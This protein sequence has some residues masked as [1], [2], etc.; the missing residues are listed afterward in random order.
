MRIDIGIIPRGL[1]KYSPN[2]KPIPRRHV[3]WVDT[4][5][6]LVIGKKDH[7]QQPPRHRH[8]I[9][10]SPKP[11]RTSRVRC[12]S[13]QFE[14]NAPFSRPARVARQP[15]TYGWSL[16][17]DLPSISGTK[18][19]HG[20]WSSLVEGYAAVVRGEGRT[21]ADVRTSSRSSI[22]KS[23]RNV[24]DSQPIPNDLE[25]DPYAMAARNRDVEMAVHLH[26]RCAPLTCN[27]RFPSC[28]FEL[29]SC[30]A[31]S[32]CA[33][34]YCESLQRRHPGRTDKTTLVALQPYE[35]LE[36]WNRNPPRT[37]A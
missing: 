5:A 22:L 18:L 16:V 36:A 28:D 10:A 8:I 19:A 15:M 33:E 24:T 26:K 31:T 2:S 3:G 20:A 12:A 35:T 14:P 25:A 13:A 34:L 9:E 11:T 17:L 7:R 21:A 4:C 29:L 30:L 27:A 6:S 23:S 37:M 32:L 1:D